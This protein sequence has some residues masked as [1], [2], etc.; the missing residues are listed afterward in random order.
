[1]SAQRILCIERA[2]LE[3]GLGR[4]L[5]VGLTTDRELFH[6]VSALL[7]SK[8]QFRLRADVEEDPTFFQPIV[9]GV[10]TDGERALALW[11]K[12]RTSAAGWYV[13]TRHNRQIGLAA[14]GHV[15]P[16]DGER[17]EDFFQHALLRELREELVFVP[18]TLSPAALFPVGILLREE[19]VFDRVHLGLIFRVPVTGTVTLP[20]GNE[21]YDRVA[22]L[23]PAEL[24]R[25]RDAMEG[26]GQILTDAILRGGFPLR[27]PAGISVS[28]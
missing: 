1:M 19:T 3:Q 13:E 16:L 6:A 18:D 7:L 27:L 22:L 10:I 20:R 9:Y 11:R 12:E 25:Y 14:G 15:E 28:G 17:Q 2:V 4:T 23:A 8:G 24:P 21:E 26:W 5:P